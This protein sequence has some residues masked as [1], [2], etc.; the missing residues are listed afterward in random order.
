MVRQEHPKQKSGGDGDNLIAR[1]KRA[2]FEFEILDTYEAGIALLGS[3]VKS[4]RNRDVSLHEAFARARGKELWLMGMNIKPYLQATIV[5]HEPLRPRKLLL[6]R[7]EIARI[8]SKISERG[9]TLVPLRLYWKRGV[10][11]V[12]LGLAR[13]KR[14]YDKRETIKKRQ[15][16]RDI[17]RTIR[18]QGR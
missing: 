10:A 11:K 18:H 17:Q 3:E 4:L 8:C 12:Q 7:K 9:L 6:H 16:E 5:N 15:A 13:G 1:N 14:R 2:R